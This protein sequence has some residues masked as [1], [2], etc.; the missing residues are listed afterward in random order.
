MNIKKYK[1]NEKGI[2]L[3]ALGI[4]VLVLLILVKVTTSRM[5]EMNSVVKQ[6]QDTKE[7]VELKGSIENQEENSVNDDAI[8]YL[9][10]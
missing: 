9:L 2:T 4:T 5:D 3:V 8:S 7:F 6:A 10:K 1:K